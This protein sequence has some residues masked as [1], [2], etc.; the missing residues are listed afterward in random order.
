MSAISNFFAPMR[1]SLISALV[2]S[3]CV[4]DSVTIAY[5]GSLMG[6]LNVLDSY[7]SYFNVTTRTQGIM[8]GATFAGAIFIAPV[9]SKI[10]DW[11]GRK[12]GVYLS[13]LMNILGAAIGAASQNTGMFIAGRVVIGMGVGIAQTSCGAYVSETTAPK[14]RAFALGLYFTCWSIGSFIATGVSRGASNLEPSNWAWRLPSLL[15][16]ALPVVVFIVLFFLP[17]SPRWLVYNGRQEEALEVLARVNGEHRDS[18]SVQVQYREIIDTLEFEKTAGRGVGFREAARNPPNRRRVLL[19]M[20]VAPLVMLA[21]SNVITYYFGTMLEQAGIDDPQTQLEINL[22]LSAFQFCCALT[23]SLL[24][25]RLGRRTLA[26]LSLGLCIV[27]FYIIGGLTAAF[28]HTGNQSGVY[29]TV[30]CI[31]LFLGSYSFG[32]TPLTQMYPPEILS[33]SIRATGAACFAV[34]NEL[35]GF[36]VTM[37][38]PYMFEGIGW[39]TYMVNASW[40]VLLWVMVWFTWVETKGKTLEEI[41]EIFD[42]E[43]HTSAPHYADLDSV[44]FVPKTMDI[45]ETEV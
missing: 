45:K 33:F 34:T 37:V 39:R 9:A 42:G 24:A 31:Y 38:F 26:L 10:I 2:I 17:E 12:T 21:G 44:R 3:V 1:M 19:A 32:I 27:F 7:N 14:I 25:E 5:D 28:G 23:G 36:F 16:G 8:S 18:A 29:A 35:C 6:S 41:S 4:V 40:N 43:K 15:Q 22:G 20:S 11:K 30:A 13:C